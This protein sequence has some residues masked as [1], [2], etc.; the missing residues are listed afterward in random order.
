[1]KRKFLELLEKDVEF[2]YSVAGYLG[3]SEILKKLDRSIEEQT[4]IWTEISKIWE[5]I[6]K[7]RED[8]VV[9]FKRHDEEIAKLREDMATGFRV[10]DNRMG[11]LEGKMGSL[12][13]R[14]DSLE[15]RMSSLE[16]RMDSLEEIMGSL[17]G[18]M[19]SLE[20]RMSS[21][22]SAMMSG[23][24]E[25]SRFAGL[26]FEEFVRRFLTERLRRSGEIPEDAE[27]RRGL[28]D[29]EEVNLFLENPLI[30]GEVTGYAESVDDMLKLLRKAELA[31]AKYSR[32][33][34]KILVILT[35]KRDTAREVRRI[36]EEK[37]VELV[38]GKTVD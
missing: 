27:L 36:A 17:E 21:L 31:K 38:I 37:D 28:V 12:E 20:G 13:R 22:E 29:G 4:K 34:R 2:R 7:L 24:G 16:G 23:F 35:A 3:L 6:R 32:E 19:G 25:L 1:M 26:T 14:M 18:R 30:V 9:G 5:E 8:M 10:F 33:P 15:G 11:S